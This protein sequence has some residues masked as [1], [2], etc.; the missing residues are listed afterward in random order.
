MSAVPTIQSFGLEG[1]EIDDDVLRHVSANRRISYLSLSRSNVKD[2]GV[3]QIAGMDMLE[4][5]DVSHTACTDAIVDGLLLLPKLKAINT[6]G[7]QITDE[8]VRRLK[9]GR[10]ETGPLVEESK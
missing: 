6:N 1:V 4:Q 3:R 8:G 9:N 2:E 5:L 7:S 10:I